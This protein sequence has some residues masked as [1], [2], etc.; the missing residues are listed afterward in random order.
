MSDGEWLAKVGCAPRANVR[1]REQ[2]RRVTSRKRRLRSERLYRSWVRRARSRG[3][4]WTQRPTHKDDGSGCLHVDGC[5]GF[6]NPAQCRRDM[7][8]PF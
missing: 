8:M 3:A 7:I 2:F 5:G 1:E 4:F 6:V